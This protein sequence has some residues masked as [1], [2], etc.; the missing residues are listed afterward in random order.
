M[1]TYPLLISLALLGFTAT[2][3]Y[4]QEGAGPM[5]DGMEE[6]S[7]SSEAP[8]A[9]GVEDEMEGAEY[10]ASYVAGEVASPALQP[11]N[12]QETFS[13]DEG[14][15]E[16]ASSEGDATP[17]ATESISLSDKSGIAPLAG[18]HHMPT[19]PASLMLPSALMPTDSGN[20]K[21]PE[22]TKKQEDPMKRTLTKKKD[23]S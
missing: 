20:Q 18:V 14:D 13:P 23:G 21:P 4:G 10:N 1:M 6:G 16:S 17:R 8:S 7:P 12:L 11:I 19:A 5:G 15:E 3:L 9:P 2:N 22:E